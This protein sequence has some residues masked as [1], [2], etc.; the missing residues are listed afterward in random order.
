MV[1]QTCT[2]RTIQQ[3]F[4]NANAIFASLEDMANLSL[5]A[6]GTLTTSGL[7]FQVTQN[8]RSAARNEGGG[9]AACRL[10]RVWSTSTACLLPL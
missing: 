5:A 9:R 6:E 3:W 1:D 2:F 10:S 4:S 7:H 8:G